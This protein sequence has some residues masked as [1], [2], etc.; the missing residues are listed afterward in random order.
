MG[1]LVRGK[2]GEL[3][4]DMGDVSTVGGSGV[5]LV[6]VGQVGTA[7]S[8]A[9]PF[10]PING[11]V[12]ERKRSYE[13]QA[14]AY[15]QS[16][17]QRSSPGYD[18]RPMW[19]SNA[20]MFAS[21]LAKTVA[22][23]PVGLVTDVVDLGHMVGDTL[24]LGA[25]DLMNGSDPVDWAGRWGNDADN[26]LTIWRREAFKTDSQM[27]QVASQLTRVVT[28]AVL[29]PKLALK[30]LSLAANASRAAEALAPLGKVTGALEAAAGSGFIQRSA[31]GI[32]YADDAV[33]N[34]TQLRRGMQPLSGGAKAAGEAIEHPWLM[35]GFGDL[36]KAGEAGTEAASWLKGV[37][38]TTKALLGKGSPQ[39][40]RIG[41]GLV[42]E[43][44]SSG[45]AAGEG[46]QQ[47]NET[48]A[49]TLSETNFMG[50]GALWR[51]NPL[52]TSV[53]DGA[54][55]LK[56]KQGLEGSLLAAPLEGTFEALRLYRFGQALKTA[57]PAE[58]QSILK[59][60]ETSKDR[61]A[62]ALGRMAITDDTADAAV[63]FDPVFNGGLTTPVA[64]TPDQIRGA[65]AQD[66]Q[67]LYTTTTDSA[68]LQQQATRLLNTV[69]NAL[70]K[71]RGEQADYLLS[72]GA[73]VNSL[74]IQHVA[75]AAW[76]NPVLTK[77]LT[78]GWV[79]LDANF[80]FAIDRL[81]AADMDAA[82]AVLRQGRK[83]SEATSQLTDGVDQN[84]AAQSVED[85]LTADVDAAAPRTPEVAAS[86]LRF[87]PADRSSMPT[88]FEYG[89]ADQG[90]NRLL[91][92]AKEKAENGEVCS[93]FL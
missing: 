78:E 48:L 91:T 73:R 81:A 66:L 27:G 79:S 69:P 89:T 5:S 70:P 32:G 51:A 82:G 40:K 64:V 7:R 65:F 55:M 33:G 83:F 3:V 1:Q 31:K 58:R 47:L 10:D 16:L 17:Q 59:V 45:L 63:S 80:G 12:S 6:D 20:G 37:Q 41:D 24:A 46:D 71:F 19:A 93:W 13:Q 49:D 50:L 22:N 23:A 86:I 38:S 76:T 4:V 44:I 14:A 85:V 77:G 56:L 87:A 61:S 2:N 30:G 35:Y 21:D 36:A 42:W 25:E 74:G 52:V 75:D 34:L 57:T 9:D 18:S 53:E 62:E 88:V 67:K 84:R 72:Y 15:E 29:L 28:G 68:V 11:Y 60:I 54:L 92:Q 26:P 43:F 90:L 8:S 39:I